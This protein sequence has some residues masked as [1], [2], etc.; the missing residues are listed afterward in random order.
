MS[1]GG[2]ARGG[3]VV[4]IKSLACLALGRPVVAVLPTSRLLDPFKLAR[5]LS[6]PLTSRKAMSKQVRLATPSECVRLTS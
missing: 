1:Q 2:G 6:L 3:A 5:A 4:P